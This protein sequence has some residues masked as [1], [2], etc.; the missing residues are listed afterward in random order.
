[1]RSPQPNTG[2]IRLKRISTL[3]GLT[4]RSPY[5]FAAFLCFLACGNPPALVVLEARETGTISQPTLII[6]RD[7]AGSGL[8]WGRSV[9]TFGDTVSGVPD[10]TGA[11]WHNNSFAYT[12]NLSAAAGVT[13]TNPTDSVG[14]PLYLLP[15]TADQAAFI[16]AHQGNSCQQTP[17]GARF[18]AWPASS[19]LR[20]RWG[21]VV[22][23]R[24]SAGS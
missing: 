21:P 24:R 12:A 5:L 19:P 22:P 20:P 18:A 9:W 1:M 3:G 4:E 2:L 17:C 13:L 8:L 23:S 10:A 15:P 7:G 14:A 11:T 16:E 6:G